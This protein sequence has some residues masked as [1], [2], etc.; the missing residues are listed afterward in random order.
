MHQEAAKTAAFPGQPFGL[1]ALRHAPVNGCVVRQHAKE[2]HPRHKRTINLLRPKGSESHH[3]VV[4]LHAQQR[5]ALEHAFDVSRTNARKDLSEK[6]GGRASVDHGR[7]ADDGL[8][9]TTRGAPSRKSSETVVFEGERR[10][11]IVVERLGLG[12]TLHQREEKNSRGIGR[13]RRTNC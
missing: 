3:T 7:D 10:Q 2:R 4:A 9:T 8:S 1:A 5:G 6:A 12:L 11:R 13:S